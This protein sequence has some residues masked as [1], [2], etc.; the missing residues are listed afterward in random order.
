M[1]HD[2]D[3]KKKEYVIPVEYKQLTEF[4]PKYYLWLSLHSELLINSILLNQILVFP[5]KCIVVIRKKLQSKETIPLW[6]L[7]D[8]HVKTGLKCFIRERIIIAQNKRCFLK[9]STVYHRRIFFEI[10]L[11]KIKNFNSYY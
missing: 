6:L 2:P 7:Q 4:S 9:Y 11:S 10:S 3:V 5:W 1:Q 8:L